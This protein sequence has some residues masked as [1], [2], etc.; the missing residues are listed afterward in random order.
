MSRSLPALCLVLVVGA[1]VLF[2]AK[3]AP[4]S[5][6]PPQKI[7]LDVQQ[8][9]FQAAALSARDR[10]FRQAVA[11]LVNPQW[12]HTP[13]TMHENRHD[14]PWLCFESWKLKVPASPDRATN[15]SPRREPGQNLGF[16]LTPEH[17]DSKTMRSLWFSG[18]Y[19]PPGNGWAAEFQYNLTTGP[20]RESLLFT[21]DHNQQLND[22]YSGAGYDVL[23]PDNSLTVHYR[24]P[25]SGDAFQVVVLLDSQL[26]Q[27]AMMTAAATPENLQQFA[28]SLCDDLEIQLRKKIVSGEVE[29]CDFDFVRSDN[30]P[31]YVPLQ[32][33]GNGP[34]LL[35]EQVRADL[36][37]TGLKQLN[38]RREV[39]KTD[40]RELHDAVVKA[41]PA[42]T[43]LKPVEQ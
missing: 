19:V 11:K 4:P 9:T 43:T 29:Y 31:R 13:L 40:F 28:L 6:P 38:A 26:Y 14:T 25:N 42:I 24:K 39:W 3:P 8:V 5:P 30:P 32:V 1:G 21:F 37:A 20:L 22:T 16:V 10:E 2:A 35:T 34:T 12:K 7:P 36:L 15:I 33:S 17:R 23:L 27:P 41:C 18:A